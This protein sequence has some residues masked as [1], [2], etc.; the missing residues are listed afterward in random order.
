MKSL[1]SKSLPLLLA[2]DQAA[3]PI[4]CVNENL[5]ADRDFN[6]ARMADTEFGSDAK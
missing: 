5:V 3:L 1:K 2:V 4:V 6:H